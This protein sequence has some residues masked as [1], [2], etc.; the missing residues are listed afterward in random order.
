MDSLRF[1]IYSFFF[2][3]LHGF[4]EFS[5]Y[6]KPSPTSRYTNFSFIIYYGIYFNNNNES[7]QTICINK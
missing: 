5:A 7:C 4:I 3:F 6:F 1:K 2:T